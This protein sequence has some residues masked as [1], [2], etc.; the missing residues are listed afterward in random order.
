MKKFGSGIPYGMDINQLGASPYPRFAISNPNPYQDGLVEDIILDEDH[1]K[2]G[3]DGVGFGDILVRFIPQDYGLPPEKLNW[4]T[5]LEMAIQE[6]PLKNEAVLLFYSFGKLYYTRRINS[7]KQ[8]SNST[9]EKLQED[10]TPEQSDTKKSQ[11]ATIAAQGGIPYQAA[12]KPTNTDI[13]F[14]NI[15]PVRPTKGDLIL[16]NRL[17]SA[18]R[19]GSSLFSNPV[20]V[21]PQPNI[22]LTAGVSQTPTEV[23]S[24]E[25][26]VYSM[27]YENMN[28]DS[29]SI[30]MVTDESLDG[31]IAGTLNS[32]AEQKA[33]LRSSGIIKETP[34]YTGAQIFINS[35]RVVL[36]SKKNELSLF[37]KR[38]INLSAI[39]LI[40]IDTE[41]SV[42]ITAN[43]D[44]TIDCDR[45]IHLNGNSISLS[46][47]T[48]LSYKT[49]GDYSILGKKIFIGSGGD[50]SQPLVLGGTLSLFMNS[51]IEAVKIILSPTTIVTTPA[52]LGTLT[53]PQVLVLLQA[54]QSQLGGTT[55]PYTAVF[56][57][58]ANFTSETNIV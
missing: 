37:S 21:T 11:S 32:A 30:W 7:T 46:A 2:Y 14:N 29:S 20:V 28:N 41:E 19:M 1:P 22:L 24:K 40:T 3:V 27:T 26:S 51:L 6:Y 48:D 36:N 18:I 42:I 55:R 16:Q 5:P 45:D 53:N 13:R 10:Y 56:N 52:G 33:H 44:I 9:W 31:F 4:A 43:K 58:R 23:S 17:G 57:S 34:Y 25:R 35:D 12:N 49:N 15:Y 8:L 47:V 38:E 50:E 54:L 39:E